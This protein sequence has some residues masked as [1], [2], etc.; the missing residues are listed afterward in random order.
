MGDRRHRSRRPAIHLPRIR[1]RASVSRDQRAAEDRKDVV[2]KPLAPR[3][4]ADDP[5]RIDAYVTPYY[6]SNGPVIRIGKYS[7]GLATKNPAAFVATI[8]S[9]KKGW[10]KLSFVELYVAAICLYD[11]GYRNEATYWFYSAQYKG[12]QFAL[13]A[14][15]KKLGGMG[16]P[17]FELD[18]AQDAFFELIGPKIN[19]YAFGDVDS[20]AKIVRRV[21]SENTG[22][23]NLPAIYPGVTF[24]SKSQ[25]QRINGRLNAGL[26]T[27]ASSLTSQ[28]DAISRQRAQNGTAARFSRLTSTPFPGGL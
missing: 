15:Q 21:Q 8:R 24:V 18:H 22:V 1:T 12:R 11:A 9:M 20:L 19:G 17:G 28:K 6:D 25:W 4:L 13:L 7:A 3:A 26:G 10:G 2:L 5:G 14:D 23:G 16:A 27:L